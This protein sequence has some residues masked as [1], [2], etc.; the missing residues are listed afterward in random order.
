MVIAGSSLPLFTYTQ[1]EAENIP[2]TLSEFPYQNL[3]QIGQKE[4]IFGVLLLDKK[5]YF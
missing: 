4:K 3:R 1:N 2:M 5:K